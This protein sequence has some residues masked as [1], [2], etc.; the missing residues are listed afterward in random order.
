MDKD[1]EESKKKNWFAGL[2]NILVLIGYYVLGI[3]LLYEGVVDIMHYFDDAQESDGI[4]LNVF[5]FILGL[6]ICFAPL[7]FYLQKKNFNEEDNHH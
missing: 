6:L 3:F 5:L 2:V 1:V 7:F 4:I